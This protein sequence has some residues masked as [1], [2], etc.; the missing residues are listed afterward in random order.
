MMRRYAFLAVCAVAAG[1]LGLFG[2]AVGLFSRGIEDLRQESESRMIAAAASVPRSLEI[3]EA[4]EGM[5]DP[6]AA[7]G[8]WLSDLASATGFERIVVA[9]SLGIVHWSGH[10]LI[11][12]GDDLRPLLLE[13]QLYRSAA[14]EGEPRFTEAHRIEGA[15]FK[16]LY[17]PARIE[18]ER[19][20][21][22]VEADQA[23]FGAATEFRN[24]TLTTAVAL[25]AILA[26][27][28]GALL[29]LSGRVRQAVKAAR[30]NERLAFLGRASAELAHELKNPLA[31]VKSSADVLRRRFDPERSDRAFGFLS[32]EVMRLS[33]LIDDI[34]TF[35]RRRPLAREPFD[36]RAAAEQSVLRLREL[37]PRVEVAVGFA[38]GLRLVGDR[39]AWNH[40]AGNLLRNAAEAME[41]SG[42]IE[43]RAEISGGACLV[44]FSDTGPGVPSEL[45]SGLFDPFVS[46]SRTGTGLGLAIVK[47]LCERSGWDIELSSNAPG[48]TEFTIRVPEG[49]WERSS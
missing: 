28:T 14:H 6:A 24:R 47:N 22:V 45:E 9:D 17:Y 44:V 37:H 33:R 43:V 18:S 29:V 19:Y 1:L 10:E 8:A 34:L 20:V 40:V 32:E 31:V 25:A 21:V 11:Q 12:R 23:Y 15:L 26:G 35:S 49:L 36:A 5:S 42:R 48:R 13:E 27:L 39:D 16:S 46:G 2:V 7:A 38:D 3:I 41:G 30:D 4:Q